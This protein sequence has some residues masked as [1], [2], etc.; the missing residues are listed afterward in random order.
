ME[1]L[2]LYFEAKELRIHAHQMGNQG[3]KGRCITA[4]YQSF[5]AAFE[6][7]LRHVE[8]V[9]KIKENGLIDDLSAAN[10][11]YDRFYQLLLSSE[12]LADITE[13]VIYGALSDT[14]R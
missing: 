5:L 2:I 14:I 7:L 4:D 6:E 9:E 1:S 11:L 12:Y 3:N 13:D 8:E 10:S